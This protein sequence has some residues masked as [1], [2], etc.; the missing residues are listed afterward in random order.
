MANALTLCN[1]SPAFWHLGSSTVPSTWMRACIPEPG[2]LKDT[3]IVTVP[4]V[5]FVNGG[6][7]QNQTT[8][9]ITADR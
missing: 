1:I 4:D 9:D 3:G 7:D 6:A 5:D 2:F 8:W